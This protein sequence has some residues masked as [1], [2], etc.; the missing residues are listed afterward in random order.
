MNFQYFKSTCIVCIAEGIEKY[1]GV[2]N[3]AWMIYAPGIPVAQ[4]L[5]CTG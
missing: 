3:N 4:D 5:G 1:K 2:L